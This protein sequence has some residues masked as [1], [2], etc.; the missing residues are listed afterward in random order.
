MNTNLVLL[1]DRDEPIV[2]FNILPSSVENELPRV[3]ESYPVADMTKKKMLAALELLGYITKA[4]RVAGI[5]VG[6]HG[7][8]VQTDPEYANYVE[9]AKQTFKEHVEYEALRR[10]IYGWWKIEY[11]KGEE[12]GR[13]VE[14]DTKLLQM[15]ITAHAPE[16]FTSRIEV[17]QEIT[18]VPV[19]IPE[20]QRAK[21][22][23]IYWESVKSLPA[24]TLKESVE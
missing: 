13:H 11:F 22:V 9:L 5:S 15:F 20:E 8:W 6:T 3:L 4:C 19:V 24:T 21:L 16:K 10:A 18:N 17:K 1:R 23:E 12:V 2:P 14:Y 7:T